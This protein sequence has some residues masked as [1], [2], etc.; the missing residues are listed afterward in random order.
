MKGEAAR[1]LRAGALL[2][3][4]GF[5]GY[6]WVGGGMV[7]YLGPRTYWVTIFGALVLGSI[8]I[9]YLATARSTAPRPGRREL[10]G[11]ALILAPIILAAAL[12]AT[13]LGALAAARKAVGATGMPLTLVPEPTGDV[14]FREIHFASTS[15]RYA[16]S[17]GVGPGTSAE[18]TG[19]VTAAPSTSPWDL[20]LTRFYISCCA[21]DAIPY[22]VA[23]DALRPGSSSPPE[24]TWLRA[25]GTLELRGDRLV[26]VARE[27]EHVRAP[28][29]PY[30][31]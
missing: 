6:L 26:L 1:L 5:Y 16:L 30:L 3:W 25:E 7:R 14:S 18:L 22:S 20:E 9:A 19:F 23:V 4:A 27:I 24:D 2:A 28:T 29:D 21:A 12:P 11:L 15:S 8:G 31:Y 17:A 13:Q 10:G